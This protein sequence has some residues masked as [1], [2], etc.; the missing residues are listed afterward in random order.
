[1]WPGGGSWPWLGQR[2]GD[3]RGGGAVQVKVTSAARMAKH[4]SVSYGTGSW[5]VS[6]SLCTSN[7]QARAAISIGDG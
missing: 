5:Q 1:M 3:G 4:V 2:G 7:R 6:G